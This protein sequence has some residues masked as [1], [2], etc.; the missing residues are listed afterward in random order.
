MVLL[1]SETEETVPDRREVGLSTG[2]S[3]LRE[4]V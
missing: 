2:S 4:F 1:L 3:K